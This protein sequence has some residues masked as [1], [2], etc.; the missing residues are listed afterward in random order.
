MSGVNCKVP[1]CTLFCTVY[2]RDPLYKVLP[3]PRF[4]FLLE[5]GAL[6]GGLVQR[7]KETGWRN[8]GYTSRMNG[9]CS[10]FG[11]SDV[12]VRTLKLQVVGLICQFAVVPTIN[13]ISE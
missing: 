12:K 9:S 7:K 5:I 2:H 10:I 8:S 13:K 1:Q 11:Q 3:L 4:I 6:E